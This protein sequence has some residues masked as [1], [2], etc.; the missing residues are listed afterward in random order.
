V[1]THWLLT[2]SRDGDDAI[3]VLSNHDP[4]EWLAMRAECQPSV[5]YVVLWAVAVTDEQAE[6]LAASGWRPGGPEK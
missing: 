3:N 2:I 1:I 4:C 6:R 5:H